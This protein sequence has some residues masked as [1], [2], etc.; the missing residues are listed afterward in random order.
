MDDEEE[1]EEETYDDIEGMTG[2]PP[3]R[4]G[5]AQASQRGVWGGG[6]DTGEVDD[7]DEDIYEVLPGTRMWLPRMQRCTTHTHRQIDSE[8][9]HT[10]T[11]S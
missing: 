4:P 7:E 11:N 3:P 8:A 5:A 9:A 2:P 1:D 10:H 6:Q